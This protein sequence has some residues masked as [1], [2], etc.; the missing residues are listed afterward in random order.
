LIYVA[1]TDRKVRCTVSEIRIVFRNF[2]KPYWHYI[3]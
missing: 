2:D 3:S 1:I